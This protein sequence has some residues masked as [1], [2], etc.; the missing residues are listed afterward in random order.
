MYFNRVIGYYGIERATAESAEEITSFLPDQPFLE[1]RGARHGLYYYLQELKNY[2]SF[3][4]II[5]PG[6]CCSILPI[7]IVAA[8]FRPIFLDISPETLH[9]DIHDVEKCA[10]QFDIAAIILVAENGITYTENDI[11]RIKNLNIKVVLDY[12]LAWQYGVNNLPHRG[13]AEIYSAGFS[14]PVSSINYGILSSREPCLKHRPYPSLRSSSNIVRSSIY[15][16]AHKILQKP[17]LGK[18]TSIALPNDKQEKYTYD[19][20]PPLPKAR[21]LATNSLIYWKRNL[22]EYLRFIQ[23]IYSV[24]L[25][26]KVQTTQDQTFEYPLSKVLVFPSRRPK[27]INL[28]FHKQYKAYQEN[29]ELGVKF[30]NHHGIESIIDS[31]YSFSVGLKAFLNRDRFLNG[32]EKDCRELS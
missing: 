14:K 21:D 2:T 20:S 24:M 10:S 6:W 11:D 15:I 27:N 8:G 31:G 9:L 4:N 17:E 16:I 18:L 32:L 5:C 1:F 25:K 19:N 23:D 29:L 7:T 12:A 26:C 22:D 3:R 13:D 28:E 30:G